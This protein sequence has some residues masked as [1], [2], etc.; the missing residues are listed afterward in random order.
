MLLL[1]FNPLLSVTAGPPNPLFNI[2]NGLACCGGGGGSGGGG[3]A[4]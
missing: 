2:P 1:G 3:S 4:G